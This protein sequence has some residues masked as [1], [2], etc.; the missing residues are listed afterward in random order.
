MRCPAAV[1]VLTALV[2][3]S[4]GLGGSP[5]GAAAGSPGW[6]IT[7][8][9]NPP[10]ATS[11]DLTGVSC[12]GQRCFAVGYYGT[13]TEGYRVL[14]ERWNGMS[15]KIQPTANAAVG[16]H[17]NNLLSAVSCASATFCAAVGASAITRGDT[18]TIRGLV[19]QWDG[20]KW[21]L[22]P[23]PLPAGASSVTLTG[24]S[25]PALGA[26]VAV[27]YYAK[28]GASSQA[29]PLAESWNGSAWAVEP[30]PNPH[31]EN[32]S[33]LSS[34][35]CTA[36]GACTAGGNFAF[37]DIN[38]SIFALRWNGAIWASQHQPNPSG[39]DDNTTSAVSCSS[40]SACTTAGSWVNGG[41]QTVMLTEHWNGT[42]WTQQKT[43][44]PAGSPDAFLDGVSC[45]AS[46]ACEAVGAWSSTAG[47][48]DRSALAERWNGT[49]WRM[50]AAPNPAGAQ[51]T[52]LNGINCTTAG[53]CAAVGSSW[54]GTGSNT[55]TL[56]EMYSR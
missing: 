32:G 37:A 53:A 49:R 51:I 9:P 55:Q 22:V 47:S 10:G 48:P 15:W 18:L 24:V 28:K 41:G 25:C 56:A 44:S 2:T 52:L 45:P 8:S 1:V 16:R 26:C 19:E 13:A 39:Q 5:A 43:P 50:Q 36:A 12:V 23:T 7:A 30:T 27:G 33:F 4:P 35:S 3:I 31:A 38:Q 21:S 46:A 29:Q 17:D 42:T 20:V 14:A 40:A 34:V 6:S 11:S 54:D